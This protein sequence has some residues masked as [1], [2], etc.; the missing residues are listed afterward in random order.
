MYV[1]KSHVD[2]DSLGFDT[3]TIEWQCTGCNHL[4]K[5]LTDSFVKPREIIKCDKQNFKISS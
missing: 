1:E 5:L 2:I 4:C 3:R